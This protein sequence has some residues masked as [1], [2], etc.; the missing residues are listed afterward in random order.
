[1]FDRLKSPDI[2]GHPDVHALAWNGR[3]LLKTLA[4]RTDFPA[5]LNALLADA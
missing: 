1:V 2:A 4:S 3:Q 5:H